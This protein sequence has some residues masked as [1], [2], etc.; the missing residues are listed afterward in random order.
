ML[1]HLGDRSG[2]VIED[3]GGNTFYWLVPPGSTLEWEEEFTPQAQVQMLSETAHVAVPGPQ[4][5]AGPQWRIPPTRMRC[6]TAAEA[7][8]DALAA[9]VSGSPD[10][11][12]H[13]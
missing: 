1:E 4:C 13:C 2:A 10:T 7:L 12:E 8:R 6:L 11:S 5:T 3:P 9:A